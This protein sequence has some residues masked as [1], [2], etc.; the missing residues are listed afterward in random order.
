MPASGLKRSSKQTRRQKCGW[1]RY[2]RAFG[3]IFPPSSDRS[4]SHFAESFQGESLYRQSHNPVCIVHF[5]L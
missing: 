5:M 2:E 3:K 4:T 1:M